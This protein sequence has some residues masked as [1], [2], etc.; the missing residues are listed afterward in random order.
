MCRKAQIQQ[1]HLGKIEE[2]PLRVLLYA[3]EHQHTNK[4]M[5][6]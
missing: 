5:H 3:Q 4:L 6:K 1:M 2:L